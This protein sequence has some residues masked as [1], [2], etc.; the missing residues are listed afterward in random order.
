M[1]RVLIICVVIATFGISATSQEQ[2]AKK[3]NIFAQALIE[4]TLAKHPE[5]TALELAARD[6]TGCSTIA[7]TDPKDIGEKCGKDELEPMRTGKPWVDQE[8]DEFDATVPLHDKAGKI[9]GTAGMDFKLKP[10]LTKAAVTEQAIKIVRELEAQLPTK[11]KL[12][13]PVP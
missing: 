7:S 6:A 11:E 4:Q 1:K 13:E 9:I 12:F 2:K 5:I 3:K 10:G 8:K